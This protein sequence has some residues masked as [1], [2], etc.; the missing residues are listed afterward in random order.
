MFLMPSRFEPC[1]LG[2][3]ISMRYGALPIAR[4]TGG[5][6]DTV[7]ELGPQK[8]TGFLFSSYDQKTLTKTIKRAI[9]LYY[10]DKEVWH[11]AQLRAMEQ[12]FSW[13]K[14]AKKYIKLYNKIADSSQ[15]VRR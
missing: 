6:K 5:L 4:A 1:G 12:D 15:I 13:T 11:Q 9:N 10:S 7:A 3:M 8:G 14:S 2:Q